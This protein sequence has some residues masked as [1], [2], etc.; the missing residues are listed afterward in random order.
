MAAIELSAAAKILSKPINDLYELGKDRFKSQ[1]LKVKTTANINKIHR[2]ISATH[3]VKTIW[4]IDKEV[5]LKSFYYPSS[6]IIDGVR[7][8]INSIK[9]LPEET[10]IVIQG[11]VG[12][13]KSIFLRY[14]SY[15]EI[16]IGSRIPVFFELRRI[17]PGETLDLHIRKSLDNFGFNT[18]QESVDFLYSSGKIVLLL[19]GFDE[20]SS[21]KVS[22]IINEIEGLSE[23]YPE[24]KIVISSRPDSGIE[25]SPYFRVYKLS[26]LQQEE[27]P[28]FLSKISN[29]KEKCTELSEA[30]K[31][32]PS[33]IK[34]LLTTPLMVTLLVL[35][36]RAENKIPEQLA[37]FY[38]NLFL[39]LLSRHDKSK[40]GYIRE[41]AT[42]LN[43]RKLQQVFEAFCYVTRKKELSTIQQIEMHSAAE[44]AF[45]LTATTCDTLDFIK[46]ITKVSNLILEEGYTY[47]FI[48][49]SVQEFYAASYIRSRPEETSA[50]FYSA[51]IYSQ[52]YKWRQEIRFLQQI[53]TYRYTKFLYIPSMS[54]T[55]NRYDIDSSTAWKPMSESQTR[56]FLEDLAIVFPK[57]DPNYGPHFTLQNIPSQYAGDQI[58]SRILGG[59]IVTSGMKLS[60]DDELSTQLINMSNKNPGIS[61]TSEEFKNT[62][63]QMP[64]YEYLKAKG[65]LPRA[66]TFIDNNFKA[67]HFELCEKIKN[68]SLEECSLDF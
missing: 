53:D 11:I 6:L 26:P 4:Q 28:D 36:Y 62:H 25:R 52:H 43:E 57:E 16:R 29:N 13:G 35:V 8:N 21:E 12:Q 31:R 23:K 7:T 17:E 46:D 66:R 54:E 51:M 38:E 64:F 10:N 61:K 27:I 24:L 41:R 59:L 18:S 14:L 3:K 45:K 44:Q 2:T 47:H 32:S 9:K 22:K 39:V 20:I 55:L 48:H 63:L 56:L 33:N 40:P 68:I 1:L 50:V 34:E 15:Q 58:M 19:D 60:I 30:I 37:D 67:L 42:D 65:K 49:K 5:S